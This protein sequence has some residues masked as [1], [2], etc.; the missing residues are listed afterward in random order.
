M[1]DE[2]HF[3][4]VVCV[5]KGFDGWIDFLGRASCGRKSSDPHPFVGRRASDQAIIQHA[6]T[7]WNGVCNSP[8][9]GRSSIPVVQSNVPWQQARLGKNDCMPFLTIRVSIDIP[10]VVQNGRAEQGVE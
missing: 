6:K 9:A 4:G 3:L 1:V 2:F 5:V 8:C 7:H 10:P